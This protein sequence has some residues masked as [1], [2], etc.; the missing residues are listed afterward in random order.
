[1]IW[2]DPQLDLDTLHS[3]I[4]TIVARFHDNASIISSVIE[5]A[6]VD[7]VVAAR[8][9]DDM[10][11][12]IA[13]GTTVLEVARAAGVIR[14]EVRPA[15]TAAALSWMTERVC[16]QAVRDADTEGLDAIAEALASIIWH[17]LQPDTKNSTLNVKGDIL[18][19]ASSPRS[20][21][22]SERSGAQ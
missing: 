17:A 10:K 4:R 16:Y 18:G 3:G 8:L 15:E 19:G 21:G 7:P 12:W 2:G 9:D 11:G 20:R 13:T 22:R 6:A 5:A 14:P 1:M